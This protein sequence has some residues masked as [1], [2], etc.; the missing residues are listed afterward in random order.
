[1]TPKKIFIFIVLLVVVGFIIAGTRGLKIESVIDGS[2]V[3]LNNGAIVSLIG[4]EPSVESQT[5]L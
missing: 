4:I 2:T 1:M 5:E 3:R